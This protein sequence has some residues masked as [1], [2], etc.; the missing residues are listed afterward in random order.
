MINFTASCRRQQDCL[1]AKNYYHKSTDNEFNILWQRT[2]TDP[3]KSR[4]NFTVRL[5]K[6]EFG[7]HW[8]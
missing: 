3:S 1:G 7:T 5:D 8:E 6:R 2:K 4:R